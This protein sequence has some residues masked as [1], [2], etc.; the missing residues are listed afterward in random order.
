MARCIA[1]FLSLEYAIKFPFAVKSSLLT[2][3]MLRFNAR[4]TSTN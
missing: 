4:G 2:S 3:G 1:L